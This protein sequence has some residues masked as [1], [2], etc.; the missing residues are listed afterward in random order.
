MPWSVTDD[1]LN[2]NTGK[3]EVRVG[4]PLT[5]HMYRP[6]CQ[7]VCP[8][9]DGRERRDILWSGGLG[10]HVSGFKTAWILSLRQ[11]QEKYSPASMQGAKG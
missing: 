11:N 3:I 4:A 6:V 1:D 10:R 9:H 2:L 5:A 7:S 8:R